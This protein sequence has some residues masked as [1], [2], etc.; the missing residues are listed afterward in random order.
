[1]ATSQAPR[2][3][4]TTPTSSLDLLGY[5]DRFSYHPGDDMSL[6][7]RGDG[8]V[9]IDL[10]H[11]TTGPQ[12]E[13]REPEVIPWT[14]SGR[15]LATPQDTCVGS[16]LVADCHGLQA[17]DHLTLTV[18]I[19]PTLV[20]GRSQT[21]WSTGPE[22]LVLAIEGSDITI[23]VPTIHGALTV[24]GGTQVELRQWYFVEV[25]ISQ[26]LVVLRIEA[27]DRSRGESS[28]HVEQPLGSAIDLGSF[29]RVTVAAE[30]LLDLANSSELVPRGRATKLFNGKIEQPILF[31]GPIDSEA[32]AAL[33]RGDLS[34]VATQACDRIVAGWDFTLEG[35]GADST[36]RSLR[37][38]KTAP[39]VLVN[40]P[41]RAVTGASW[42]GRYNNFCER[43][44][45]YAA[46]HFHESDL[47]DAGWDPILRDRLPSDLP[48]GV[49]GLR[50]RSQ[51]NQ[52]VVP[53]AITPREDQTGKHPIVVV[54]PSFSYLAYGNE[55]NFSVL[56]PSVMSGGLSLRDYDRDR[57]GRQDF[58]QSMYDTHADG[59]GVAFSSW[60]RPLPNMRHDY[61]WWGMGDRGGH[62]L[63]CDMQLIEWLTLEG[64][65]H[66]VM[67]DQEVH[68]GGSEVLLDYSVVIT[69]SHPEYSSGE[70]LSAY[71][72]Y[73][74]A[75]GHLVYL[76]GNG[77]Y[78]VTQVY[79]AEPFVVEIRR[80]HSGIRCWESPP[81]EVTLV[82]TGEPGGLWRHRG[83]APQRLVGVGMSC[84]GLDDGIGYRRNPTAASASCDWILDGV[85]EEPIGAYGFALNGAAGLECDRADY[86][87]GTPPQATVLASAWGFS[88]NYQRAIEELSMTSPGA[89]DGTNDPDVRADLLH[90]AFPGGG[91]VFSVGSMT[92]IGSLL[93]NDGH[94]GVA[95][96]TGNVVHRFAM[97]P[98]PR[99][100]PLDTQPQR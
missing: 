71:A 19:W 96:L 27:L 98:A 43:A 79:S 5:T 21:I 49:Y 42:T 54:L 18:M 57:V 8:L 72:G 59:S 61:R 78:W 60:R 80:G 95:R 39:G 7:V 45:E 63:P 32:R 41:T 22:G 99:R 11:L 93:H 13:D 94:N 9:E 51:R 84:Q 83:H 24:S 82:S 85:E 6:M 90:C 2:G 46:I 58:G 40:L 10:V 87:L 29:E 31:D 50:V 66:D 23:R 48:S 35:P 91:E 75:G 65:P 26:S 64:I 68:R 47:G 12:V 62:Q 17:P 1:M 38:D 77:F 74:D 81:G 20:S 33:S 30:E 92:W 67:T 69:C 28:W 89:G 25:E 4:L 97:E 70:L 36:V 88:T 14:P 3:T 86:L 76:G 53:I 56:E 100:R 16:F 44:T 55:T 73:R 15:Y 52:D 34:G 37:N